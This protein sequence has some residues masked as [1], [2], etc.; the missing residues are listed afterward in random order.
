VSAPSGDL[1]E[2]LVALTGNRPWW[3]LVEPTP[4]WVRVRLGD[5]L[6]ADSRRALLHVQYGPGALPHSFL[7]TYYLPPDDVVPG[8]LVEPV[9]EPDG[10]TVWTVQAGGT[11]AEGAAWAHRALPEPLAALAGLVTFSWNDPLA[12]FEEDEPLLAHARDPH[13]RVDVVQS[14]RHVRVEVD[15]A[16][17]AESRRPL[18]LFET[19]LPA[20]YYLPADDVRVPLVRSETRS[21]CPYK[22]VATWWSARLG[23]RLLADVAWSYPDP[24]P[25]N[26][27]IAGLICFRNERVDLTVDGERM[28]RPVT[29]WS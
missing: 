15:G 27:R 22:G 16:L 29:P 26:P 2:R 17:L 25:E 23:D 1:A 3:P 12:W 10:R 21:V 20:R 7:P 4:R 13:K 28:E 5:D 14:S 19:S 6:V 24:V 11:R 8:T 18:L 9:D